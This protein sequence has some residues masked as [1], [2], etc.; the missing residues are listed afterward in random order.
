MEFWLRCVDVYTGLR[1]NMYFFLWVRDKMLQSHWSK[2]KS[3]NDNSVILQMPVWLRWSV[4]F[5]ERCSSWVFM[6]AN[7]SFYY[8]DFYRY[9]KMLLD[10]KAF[11]AFFPPV[12]TTLKLHT[13]LDL[14]FKWIWTLML[15]FFKITCMVMCRKSP[16]PWNKLFFFNSKTSIVI[17]WKNTKIIWMG[18]ILCKS[19]KVFLSCRKHCVSCPL[20]SQGCPF[21]PLPPGTRQQRR[22]AV[23]HCKPD[24]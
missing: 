6:P 18:N 1:C 14:R 5:F 3:R 10:M 11:A 24:P 8:F 23:A 21:P 13:F 7:S 2:P 16:K 20:K 22:A 15:H 17:L 12:M 9:S 19:S 4:C